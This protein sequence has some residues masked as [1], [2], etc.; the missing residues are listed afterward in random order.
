MRKSAGCHYIEVEREGR[1]RENIN[2]V[3]TSD[4]SGY[5]QENLLSGGELC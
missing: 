4:Y 2:Y 3:G 5:P 1:E